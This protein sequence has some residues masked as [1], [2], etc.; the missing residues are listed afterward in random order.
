MKD[1]ANNILTFLPS[2]TWEQVSGGLLFAAIIFVIGIGLSIVLALAVKII[3]QRILESRVEKGNLQQE[4]AKRIKTLLRLVKQG[5]LLAIWAVLLL[6]ALQKFGIDIAPLLA[7]AGIVGVALGFGSQHLVRDLI[8]GAFIIM[9]NQI[10]VG[11]VAIIN[12]TGGLVE[13]INLRTIILRDVGGIVHIF[14][15]GSITTL[16]NMTNTW[17]AYVFEIGVAY[18]EDV[19]KVI[20]ILQNVGAQ[21]REDATVGPKI[22][23]DVDVYGLDKMADSALII[24]GRIKTKPIEQWSVGRAFLKQVKIAFDKEGIEIPFPHRKLIMPTEFTF[25]AALEPKVK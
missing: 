6:V 5:V 22:L 14:P 7:G 3:E 10:R 17:S 19:D 13:E 25:P 18:H 24:K 11:D 12:G 8:S 15:A 21:L 23:E 2:F 4:S 16:S 1:T 9:E 20:A